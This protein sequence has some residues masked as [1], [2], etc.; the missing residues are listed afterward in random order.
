M[1][2][3]EGDYYGQTVNVASRI[4][5]YARPGEVLVSQ[6]VV[7]ASG[8]VEVAFREIGP[9]E[10]KGVVVPCA[11]TRPPGPGKPGAAGGRVS[12]A[13]VWGSTDQPYAPSGDQDREGVHPPMVLPRYRAQTAG[14]EVGPRREFVT[15]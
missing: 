1:I 7:D 15:T 5:K 6:E 9:V 13:V 11:C 2:F 14:A 4:A 3:Q 10:L 12:L 8:G